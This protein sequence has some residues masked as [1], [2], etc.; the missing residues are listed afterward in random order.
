MGG[1]QSVSEWEPMVEPTAFRCSTRLMTQT[2]PCA[3]H[4]QAADGYIMQRSRPAGSDQQ[5]IRADYSIRH[6]T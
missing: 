3:S 5:V 2:A 6:F 4:K 1:N